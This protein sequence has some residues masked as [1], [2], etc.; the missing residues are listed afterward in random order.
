MHAPAPVP[1]AVSALPV[2]QVFV[3]SQHPA[4]LALQAPASPRSA[5]SEALLPSSPLEP[6]PPPSPPLPTVASSAPGEESSPAYPPSKEDASS[7]PCDGEPLL[8]VVPV[9]GKLPVGELVS[10]DSP[11]A[12]DSDS[13]ATKKAAPK[14]RRIVRPVKAKVTLAPI[15]VVRHGRAFFRRKKGKPVEP[16]GT[17][18]RTWP[19][20]AP[21][22]AL[23]GASPPPGVCFE[24]ELLQRSAAARPDTA[25]YGIPAVRW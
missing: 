25:S 14:A 2:W 6:D 9:E 1:H 19:H 24:R 17:H 10:T 3:W 7:A 21:P 22:D 8:E 18:G 11:L 20:P 15:G 5:A 13:A 16:I 12:H 4:Q 23:L